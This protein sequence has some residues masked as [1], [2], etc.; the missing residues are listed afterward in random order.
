M[1]RCFEVALCVAAL[2][3][4][5]VQPSWAQESRGGGTL[6]IRPADANEASLTEVSHTP[7]SRQATT[8]QDVEQL[9]PPISTGAQFEP[10]YYR[11]VVPGSN[12]V[13]PRA[14]RLKRTQR[15]F[16]TW[17]GFEM[18][19]SGSRIFIQ[20]T[21]PVS[22]VREDDTNR[23][24]LV[25]NKTRIHLRNNRNPLVTE[26]FN[27]PVARAYLRHRRRDT[28]LIL[29]MKVN[30][31]PSIRQMSEGNYHFLMLEFPSGNYPIPEG[32]R[33]W[34]GGMRISTP[35]TSPQYKSP[36]KTF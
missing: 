31:S 28:L 21:H 36:P 10:G 23:V 11:G 20:S 18:T 6:V 19:S 7:T 14:R 29:E 35:D 34:R 3:L 17:P 30:S 26:H 13:P 22:Y 4:M 15:N 16:V 12:H 32:V 25:L 1:I 9:R 27:T 5:D 33:E 8:A 24:V 2:L